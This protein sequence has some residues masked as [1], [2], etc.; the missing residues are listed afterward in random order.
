MTEFTDYYLLL[1]IEYDA[2]SSEIK[3][4]YL[5][6]AKEAH[7]DAGGS[8]EA[9][10]HLNHAYR[11]LMVPEKRA[12]YNKLYSL[13]N[14]VAL[15]DLE[16]KEDGY[17]VPGGGDKTDTGYE[18]FFIDQVYAEYSEPAKKSKWKDKFKRK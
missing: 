8:N 12:A 18:D 5:K 1:G 15:D 11:T 7:P 2:E 10:Q 17:D 6:L 3:R 16:L 9:M 13:H 4:A 14:R